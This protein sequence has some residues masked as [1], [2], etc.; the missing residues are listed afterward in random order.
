MQEARHFRDGGL[1]RQ[2][3]HAAFAAKDEED[4]CDGLERRRCRPLRPHEQLQQR[5]RTQQPLGEFF[6]QRLHGL[7]VGLGVLRC[8]VQFILVTLG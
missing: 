4:P 8:A 3:V 6:Q 2:E 5:L 1:L 7:K